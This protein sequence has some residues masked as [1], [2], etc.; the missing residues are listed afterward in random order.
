MG[1]RLRQAGPGLLAAALALAYLVWEPPSADLAAQVFRT[2]LFEQVGFTVWSNQW[3]AG[4]HVPGYSVLFPPLAAILGPRLVAAVSAVLAAVLFERLA[5]GRYGARAWLGSLWFGA[6]TATNLFTGRLTFA[7]GV[8][9]GLGALLAL[10][11]GRGA[12][13]IVLAV[14]C[15]LAS[16]VAGLFLAL[17]ALA[18]ALSARRRDA[19]GVAVGAIATSAV[20]QA[21]FPEGGVEPFVLSAFWPTVAFAGALLV[22]V[23]RDSRTLRIAAV[24]YGVA[25]LAA[26]AV[27]TPMGGN[28]TRLGTLFGGPVLA[29]ALWRRRNLALGLL[30]P[31]LLYWQWSAPVRDVSTAIAD[32]AAAAAY[33]EPLNR[34][35]A[36]R[37][38]LQRVEIPLT[39]NHWENAWVAIR[40]PLARGWERQL[41]HRYN[42]LFYEDGLDPVRYRAWLRRLAVDYVAVPDARLDYT[43][44]PEARLV[45]R[46]L[47][48]LT[49]VWRSAHWRVYRVRGAAAL[50]A[51]PGRIVGQGPNWFELDADR[52]GTFVVGFRHTPYW[53]VQTGRACVE[54]DGDG[55][56]R[57]VVRRAGRVR[58]GA[59]FE[60]RRVLSG[61][62][63]CRGEG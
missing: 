30:A 12:V 43:G 24:L 40:F 25:C 20:L 55:F 51:G 57:V 46:G 32:P 14:L 21:A 42:G 41:D 7:L 4:H 58:I 56:T 36:T 52:P 62:G 39:R 23:P 44:M 35:L 1:V 6:A 59:R 34:F 47:P 3:F 17:A 2:R 63:A 31:G 50:A 8:M 53:A 48:F 60:P 33:Y 45:R 26:F 9:I 29:L 11:R 13:A 19:A 37:Q 5:A 28:V 54:P 38:G 10:Q 22:L 18:F 61:R 49:P 16:P 15:P 27:A